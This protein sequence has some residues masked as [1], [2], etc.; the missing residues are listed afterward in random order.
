M[1]K[2]VAW[3]T[4]GSAA[5]DRAL[6]HARVLGG[7]S[8]GEVHLVHRDEFCRVLGVPRGS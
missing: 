3:A 4:D 2:H 7:H 6:A 1:Y 5:A 8:S